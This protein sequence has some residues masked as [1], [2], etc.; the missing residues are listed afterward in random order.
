MSDAAVRHLES[1]GVV[2]GLRAGVVAD[3]KPV[4]AYR[5]D[6]E[7]PKQAEGCKDAFRAEVND[8]HYFILAHQAEV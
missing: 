5:G 7:H 6:N 1:A 4:E 8:V 2:V 3:Y